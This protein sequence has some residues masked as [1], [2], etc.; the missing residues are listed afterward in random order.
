MMDQIFDFFS[1]N[2]TERPQ[3]PPPPLK[4]FTKSVTEALFSQ[5]ELSPTSILANLATT[6]IM[7]L[8]LFVAYTGLPKYFCKFW[9]WLCNKPTTVE[10]SITHP[11]HRPLMNQ[12]KTNFESKVNALVES[13]I[14]GVIEDW[15]KQSHEIQ[16][17]T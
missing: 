12:R 6:F 16:S 7:A 5:L 15:S 1:G 9:N 14:E 10:S 17:G 2:S 11:I 13:R 8:L 4:N 3:I